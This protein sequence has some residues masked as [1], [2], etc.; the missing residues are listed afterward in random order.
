MAG[1]VIPLS[2]E[3]PGPSIRPDRATRS[4]YRPVFAGATPERAG[5][6][7]RPPNSRARVHLGHDFREEGIP[8]AK[9]ARRGG[10]QYKQQR[11]TGVVSRVPRISLALPAQ[12]MDRN[13]EQWIDT[14]QHEQGQN[15]VFHHDGSRTAAMRDFNYELKRLCQRNRDGSYATRADRER[16]LDLVANQ[17]QEMG[18]RHMQ[19][20]SLKPK[21][22][23][24]LVARW[25]TEQ[26]A[27]ATFKNRMAQLRWLAEKTG[28]QGVVARTNDEY[29]IPERTYVTNVS[30][31]VEL[32]AKSLERVTDP[33]TALSLRLQ[34]AFGLR[35]EESIKFQPVW[36]DRGDKIV[37][38]PS[39]AKGKRTR[40]I[41]V[42]SCEQRQLLD[43]ARQFTGRGSLI[44]KDMTYVDQLQ[45]FKAQCDAAGIHH[46]HGHRHHYA[47]MRYR[48]LTGWVCPVQGGPT[49]RQLTS[50][51][52][53]IDREARLTI[54][55]E[56]GRSREQ[57]VSIYIGR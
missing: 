30:K 7:Q 19:A 25:H 21:H 8:D 11:K 34:S 15:D 50:E 48:E 12:G 43:E 54:S 6:N 26:I 3:L 18:F 47:Q 2:D 5:P 45:R 4:A 38:K 40:E 13:T 55:S 16:I 22:V 32:D 23:E 44:P 27:P 52:K 41:P 31:A 10:K 29:G 37:L 33:Y 35:R 20:T 56:L 24:A 1:A 57:V 49:S 42:R 46:V 17:L 39:W 28:K 53:A 36:A 9:T 51:Q 14:R